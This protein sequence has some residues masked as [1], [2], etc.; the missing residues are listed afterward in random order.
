MLADAYW[1]DGRRDDALEQARR[2]DPTRVRL[3]EML[4]DGRDAEAA[5]W[6]STLPPDSETPGALAGYYARAGAI[7]E[8]LR[9]LEESFRN[10][11]PNLPLTLGRPELQALNDD[12]RL[13]ELRRSMG[14]LPSE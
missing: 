9:L 4:A 11:V 1:E 2:H 12:P 5:A 6:L 7:D 3:F 10:R 13:I 14:L 8:A